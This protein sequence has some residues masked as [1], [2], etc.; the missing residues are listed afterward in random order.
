ML[1]MELAYGRHS[2]EVFKQAPFADLS[3]EP[4]EKKTRWLVEHE[5][6]SITVMK[7]HLEYGELIHLLK[8]PVHKGNLIA[9]R[10]EGGFGEPF[11]K[12]NLTTF[13]SHGMEQQIGA[14]ELS[15]EKKG[16]FI[17]EVQVMPGT[18]K[19]RVSK[20]G[21]YGHLTG[22]YG[23]GENTIKLSDEF[24]RIEDATSPYMIKFE[25]PIVGKYYGYRKKGL[26]RLLIQLV[27][28]ISR[29]HG[30]DKIEGFFHSRTTGRFL[31]KHGWT[32]HP[33]EQAYVHGE[34]KL[35]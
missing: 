4:V 20:E 22:I 12:Y 16:S 34:K 25:P 35:N 24:Q 26:G 2:L 15:E 10:K 8:D 23:R 6:R 1:K 27:E 32:I 11:G 30:H 21:L 3:V 29:K 9:V 19:K 7:K 14:I 33:S 5:G 18:F 13:R 28:E 31:P 17:N